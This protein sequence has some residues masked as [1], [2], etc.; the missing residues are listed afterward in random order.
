MFCLAQRTSP[1]N[2][3]AA[4]AVL[5]V[6]ATT[7][8]TA[9]E[10]SVPAQG[11]ATATDEKSLPGSPGAAELPPVVVT[12][13]EGEPEGKT[14]SKKP[15][16]PVDAASPSAA[17]PTTAPASSG[18]SVDGAGATLPPTDNE[19]IGSGRGTGYATTLTRSATKLPGLLIETPVSVQ[20]VPRAILDDQGATQLPDAVENVS[21]VTFQPSS[22]NEFDNFSIRGFT[23]DG[24]GQVF[25]D[26]VRLPGGN[27]KFGL[28]NVDRI[29]VVKG[30]SSVLY[31]R[32]A[33]GGFINIVTKKPLDT[34]YYSVEQQFATFQ[35][36]NTLVDVTGPA[37]AD[38]SVLYRVNLGYLDSDS[39]RDFVT[40]EAFFLAPSVTWRPTTD[41]Q[42]NFNVEFSNTAFVYD[43]GIP[44]QD[45]GTPIDVPLSRQLSEPGLEER[46]RGTLIDFNWSYKPDS[47]FTL[48][49]AVVYRNRDIDLA[50]VSGTD[51]G[52]D[53]RTVERFIAIGPHSDDLFS[54]SLDLAASF[55]WAGVKHQALV[56]VDYFRNE[57]DETLLVNFGG[58]FSAPID[59]FDPVYGQFFDA[60]GNPLTFDE[61]IARPPN[62]INGGTT[63][64]YGAYF[65]DKIT[66]WDRLHILAGG[67]FDWATTTTRFALD[68]LSSVFE[69]TIDE[70]AFTPRVG[71]VYQPLPWLS[72][73]G[74]YVQ[75]FG[76]SNGRSGTGAAL[77]AQRSE[78]YEAGLK[79]ESLDH[80][81]AASLAVFQLERQRLAVADVATPDPGDLITIGE[82][83]SRGVELDVAGHVTDRLSLFAS[84]ALIDAIVTSDEQQDDFGNPIDSL[85][86]NRLVGVPRHSGSLFAK[87][88]LIPKT[89]EIGGGV[90]AVGDSAGDSANSYSNQAYARLD[91]FAAYHWTSGQQK[92]TAQLNVKNLLDTEYFLPTDINGG[93]TAYPGEPLTVFG[94][95]RV[96]N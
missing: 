80:R 39:F 8:A 2:L 63:S 22:G 68:D 91:A 9:Q 52:P 17:L 87:Y 66:L 61:L 15:A 79:F 32:L 71:L 58:E 43:S 16:P 40:D 67:R 83:R 47:I 45:D 42:A 41:F 75:G 64:W 37:T 7:A 86:G 36:F 90:F 62:L 49:N 88:E 35:F 38:K 28:V 1:P 57:V 21:G 73:Y 55:H 30:P 46:Q 53:G 18:E 95:I 27:T 77:P 6:L 26:G 19:G 44:R 14:V 94:S 78:Q 12:Q 65:Q 82:A 93:N 20:V 76:A 84:Y 48:S 81:L 50:E 89:L 31:G 60:N 59:A 85:E 4:T 23:D 70:Q 5:I 96:A 69:D 24:L 74:N 56:G 29:E 11:S 72:L 92:W 3:L 33:P 54:T 51:L 25:R 10:P 34:A 13:Q